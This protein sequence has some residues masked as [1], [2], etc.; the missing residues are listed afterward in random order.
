MEPNELNS[1][2]EASFREIEEETGFKKMILITL[3]L[4]NST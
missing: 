2:I 4:N 1:P 3:G